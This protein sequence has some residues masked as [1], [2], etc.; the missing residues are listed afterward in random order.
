MPALPGMGNEPTVPAQYASLVD[1]VLL[2]IL[3]IAP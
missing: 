3:N 2:P 1:R